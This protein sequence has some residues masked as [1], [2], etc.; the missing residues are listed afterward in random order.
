MTSISLRDFSH[1]VVLTGA[2][3]SAP[4][5]L[6]TYRGPNGLWTSAKTSRFSNAENFAHEADAFW[7]FWGERRQ[8][9]TAATPNAAHKTLAAWETELAPSQRFTLITQNIDEL[10]KRA[11]SANA[12]ELHGSLFRTKCSSANC[13]LVPYE[14]SKTYL[15]KAPLCT[16]C[17]AY[18]RPDVT[19]FGEM[20]PVEAA[21]K[22]KQAFRDCSLFIAVGTSGTVSPASSFVDWAKLAG[23][24]TISVNVEKMQP[25]NFAFDEEIIGP[26]EEILA[27]K[28]EI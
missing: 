27:S 4:S 16:I 23:A 1:I 14:D 18:L 28:F 22:S 21:H 9:A 12:I 24:R 20:L 5:G 10:H 8:D 11:G 6:A 7:G 26:A 2:G 17:G 15:D 13:S 25:R 19:F 3:V